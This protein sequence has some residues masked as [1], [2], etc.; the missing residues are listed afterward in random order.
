M[1]PSIF[2]LFEFMYERMGIFI[3]TEELRHAIFLN[4]KTACMGSVSSY[5]SRL[6]SCLNRCETA[7]W[8][9]TSVIG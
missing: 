6:R 5:I 1:T 8:I 2:H 4:G 7:E 9:Q 3:S